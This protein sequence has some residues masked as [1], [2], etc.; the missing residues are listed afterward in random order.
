MLL[1]F[2][3]HET[4]LMKIK[5]NLVTL[6]SIWL[7]HMSN[8]AA[9]HKPRCIIPMSLFMTNWVNP[10]KSFTVNKSRHVDDRNLMARQDKGIF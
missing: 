6:F 8:T 9:L 7:A 3:A 2:Q 10:L 1:H 4:P 5:I